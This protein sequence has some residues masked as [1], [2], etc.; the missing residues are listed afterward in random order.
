MLAVHEAAWAA[1]GGD[2]KAKGVSYWGLSY[3]TALGMTF[4]QLYPERVERMIL[5]GVVDVKDYFAAKWEKNLQDAD[6]AL[7]RFFVL[8]DSAKAGKCGFAANSTSVGELRKRWEGL[9]EKMEQHPIPLFGDAAPGSVTKDA[10]LGFVL[11][12]LFDPTAFP[13]V[14][15]VLT[16]LLKG[17]GT[18]LASLTD[19]PVDP[20]LPNGSGNEAGF[21]V[22][23][24]DAFSVHGRPTIAIAMLRKHLR[25]LEKQTRWFSGVWGVIRKDCTG[26]EK[27]ALGVQ[28][29]SSWG[30]ELKNKIL[31]VGNEWD[32][33]TPVRNAKAMSKLWPGSGFLLIKGAPGHCTLVTNGTCMVEKYEKYLET[34]K[35]SGGESCQA[36]GLEPF[37]VPV[38]E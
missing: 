17:N 22:Y 36:D 16:N 21:A 28:R 10:L 25:V 37:E 14:D 3:G 23:C 35:V 7:E 19:L 27:P 6:A 38:P 4:A 24:S 13:L 5:D 20:T 11:T 12:A 8:C 30:R 9:V 1:A 32:P 18:L 29:P 2:G 31:F 34:G 26:W 15:T 33:V